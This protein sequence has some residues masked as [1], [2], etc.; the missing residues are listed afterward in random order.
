MSNYKHNTLYLIWNDPESHNNF[1]VGILLR[2]NTYRFLYY[3][4]YKEAQK[5]GWRFL[6]AFPQDVEYECDELFSA[7][8]CRLPDRKRHG[9]ED[10]LKKYGLESYD[11][12]E[13]LRAGGGK[14]PIDSYSFIDPIFPEDETIERD[15]YIAGFRYH[16]GCKENCCDK[17]VKVCVGEQLTFKCEP[18]NTHDK[19]AVVIFNSLNQKLGYVPRYYSEAVTNRINKKMTYSCKV[20]EV[21]KDLECTECVKVRLNMP[22][23]IKCKS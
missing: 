15:F 4:D 19:Y 12:F 14:L 22:S 13:L 7:F 23:V 2:D 8:A 16:A 6:P 18:E 20:T 10:I 17:S 9:I 11:E 21:N 3:G 1:V 5:K